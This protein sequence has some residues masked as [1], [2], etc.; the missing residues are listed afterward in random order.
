MD[1]FRT[2]FETSQRRTIAAA[3]RIVGNRAEAEEIAQDAFLEVWRRSR[4][5]GVAPDPTW[6][7]T[8]VRCRAIDRIRRRRTASVTARALAGIPASAWGRDFDRAEDHADQD[9]VQTALL[10]LSPAQR[11]AVQLVYLKGLTHQQ[12][13]EFAGIPL[14]TLKTR[15]RLAI[16]R[17]ARAL[18]SGPQEH[19]GEDDHEAHPGVVVSKVE[20]SAVRGDHAAGN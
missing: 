18:A 13:A 20:S 17:L 6:V 9:A 19:P 10:R 8:T 14:G 4:E 2:L 12:A 11:E 3:Q 15:V 7:N 1:S 5:A 16:A